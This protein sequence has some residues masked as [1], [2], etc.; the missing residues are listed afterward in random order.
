MA[1]K[2]LSLDELIAELRSG[3]TIGI[4]GWGSRRKPMAAIRAILRSDL[5]DLTVVSYG[6]PDVGLLCA[7][8]KVKQV[9]Y[10]F[11]T[12][13]SI[14]TDPHFRAARQAGAVETMEVD[15]GMF[16][17][18][19]LAA[20]Q[21]VPFLPTRAGLG[22]DVMARNPS[23][24]TITSPYD[25]GEELV[26]MPALTLDAAVVHVNR[27]DAGGSGQ[28]LGPDP[29]FDEL[30]LGAA[31][32]RYV[33]TEQLVPTEQFASEGPIQTLCISRL[34]TDGV[35]E[36]PGGAHFTA[37]VPDYPRDEAFQK[38]Y[39]A[40]AGDPDSWASFRRQY[41]ELDE[42]GYQEARREP[43]ATPAGGSR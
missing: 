21:R 16:Y 18:G 33:T 22:S 10:A 38:A 17:L 30:F 31:Q 37:C 12:L 4:G 11:V 7:A 42:A 27:A 2:R 24:R 13:D 8:G 43:V 34:L 39:A 1:D 41:L 14:P 36:T 6:G 28:I 32:R 40:A 3:M 20:S 23:L 25:D 26:A 19:L 9:V 5:T 15:E 35:V 29:F